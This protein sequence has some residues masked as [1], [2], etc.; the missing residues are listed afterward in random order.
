MTIMLLTVTISFLV[1]LAW[2]CITQ[3][4]WM[5]EYGKTPKDPNSSTWQIVDTS[6]AFAKL[7]VIINSSINWFFYCITSTMFRNEM[8]KIV[9]KVKNNYSA[10]FSS[11]AGT[12][13]I[14]KDVIIVN[15]NA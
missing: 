6:F 12:G 15:S 8:R 7:G 4:F 13:S 2:Q 3:C 14:T 1:L 10:T 5:L 11:S 9:S